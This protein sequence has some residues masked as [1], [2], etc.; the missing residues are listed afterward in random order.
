M[1][2]APRRLRQR[3]IRNHIRDGKR[4]AHSAAESCADPVH[5]ELSDLVHVDLRHVLC[6]LFGR[7][8]QQPP[9]VGFRFGAGFVMRVDHG[10]FWLGFGF[11]V[12]LIF[13]LL[14]LNGLLVG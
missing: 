4:P 1:P 7:D 8:S 12:L 2:L 10:S 3:K 13:G 11:A 5:D 6:S 9:F 14:L